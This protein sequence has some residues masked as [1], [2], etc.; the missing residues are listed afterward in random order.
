MILILILSVQAG[1][2]D[3]GRC[4]TAALKP[5]L[6]A[7]M[8]LVFETKGTTSVGVLQEQD[9]VE[10]SNVQVGRID[11]E[12]SLEQRMVKLRELLARHSTD[13]VA[14]NEPVHSEH[15]VVVVVV[16]VVRVH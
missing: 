2:E 16:V 1:Q 3:D 15:L 14:S 8:S 7:L 10:D 6:M 13:E 5:A 12:G 9:A 4:E 11:V